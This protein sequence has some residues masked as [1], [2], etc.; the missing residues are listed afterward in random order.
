MQKIRYVLLGLITAFHASAVIAQQLDVEIK[1]MK[2]DG[3]AA[4]CGSSRVEGLNPNGDG[5]LA[6]RTGPG[7][8][9]RKIDQIYNGDI[10]ADCNQRGKWHGIFYGP[11]NK[12]KGWVHGN[13]LVWV[14][15]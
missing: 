10:V 14:A 4:I 11:N 8:K 12:K 13:W 1:V 2:G 9:Y 3:Q 6:V 7:S 15:G 5:F